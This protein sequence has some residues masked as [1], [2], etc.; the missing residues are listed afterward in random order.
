G[1]HRSSW[2]DVADC[3]GRSAARRAARS[4]F[5]LLDAA[6]DLVEPLVGLLRRLVGRFGALRGAL[7][8]RV[9]L[10]E[11]RVDRREL[12]GVGRTA[13]QAGGG[14]D[15]HAEHACLEVSLAYGHFGCSF[16]RDGANIAGIASRPRRDSRVRWST[17][18]DCEGGVKARVPAGP[19][20]RAEGT[21]S[22]P[23]RGTG[24]RA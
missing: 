23:G 6:L 11:A 13:G 21:A 3:A 12:V 17:C 22:R 10:V 9:E 1:G 20:H 7:H 14:N 2:T 19:A 18:W 5:E 8:P 15:R 4:R 16:V 24:P